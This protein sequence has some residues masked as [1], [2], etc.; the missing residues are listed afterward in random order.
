[1]NARPCRNRNSGQTA[2]QEAT[3][4]EVGKLDLVQLLLDANADI[5]APAAHLAA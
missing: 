4:A 5:N 1:M 3:S 2:L